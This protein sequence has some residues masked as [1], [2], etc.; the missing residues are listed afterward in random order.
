MSRSQVCTIF[1][2][3][4][5]AC[6]ACGLVNIL[7]SNRKIKSHLN[8]KARNSLL[9]IKEPEIFRSLGDYGS[10]HTLGGSPDPEDELRQRRFNLQVGKGL[11]VLRR[12]LPLVFFASNL[13]FSI[14][15]PE[16]LV[17]DGNNNRMQMQKAL[18]STVVKSL[19]LASS[20]SS[21]YPSM[22]VQKIE[23]IEDCSTIQCL[24]EVILPDSIRID[25]QAVW[26]GMFYFGLDS[27]GLISSH[28][29]DRKISNKTPINRM[30]TK[31]FPWLRSD[32]Q[33]SADL[34]VGVGSRYDEES[35]Q[36]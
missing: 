28:T 25:G 35:N 1:V 19:K 15:A 29:F 23:Y 34:L 26:G 12:E 5:F 24:V 27:H 21:M 31:V 3:L 4:Y 10:D 7:S 14:F 22:N 6:F 11:E 18:Y 16:I 20:F 13:D 33:W 2:L 8:L 9:E 30:N 36:E 17:S 32:A